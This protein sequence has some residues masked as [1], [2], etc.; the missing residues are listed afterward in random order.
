MSPATTLPSNQDLLNAINRLA[1]R[2][3]RLE[4]EVRELTTMVSSL[5][6]K[7]E[8]LDAKVEETRDMVGSLS[9]TVT[10]PGRTGTG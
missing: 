5:D 7:V 4:G 10:R 9:L 3:D 1:D 8:S 6:A 2:M